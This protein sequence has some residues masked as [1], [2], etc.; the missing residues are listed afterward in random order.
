MTSVE[1]IEQLI[2]PFLLRDISFNIDNK[3]VKTGKLILFS[4]KDFFCVFTLTTPDR[5]N[6]RYI[7]EIPYPFTT[8][9]T[10]SSLEFDYT[11]ESFC[12]GNEN[13]AQATKKIT[14]NRPSKLFNKKMVVIAN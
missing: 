4:I 7:Y 10:I 13:I 8:N 12:L 2:K 6:K 11:L 1:N 9:T 3:T 5:G 14:Y